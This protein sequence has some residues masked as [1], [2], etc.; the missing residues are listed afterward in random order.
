MFP[1]QQSSRRTCPPHEVTLLPFWFPESP[2]QYF[3][4]GQSATVSQWGLSSVATHVPVVGS[5]LHRT[6][7]PAGGHAGLFGTGTQGFAQ[8]P[9]PRHCPPIG[10]QSVP[11]FVPP[12]HVR[13]QKLSA[14]AAHC[15]PVRVHRDGQK[16]PASFPPSQNDLRPTCWTQLA[17]GAPPLQSAFVSQPRPAFGPSMHRFMKQLLPGQSESAV[18]AMPALAPPMHILDGHPSFAGCEKVP[19]LPSSQGVPFGDLTGVMHSPPITHSL[20][21]HGSDV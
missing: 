12:T 19:S 2:M 9:P 3:V 21:L 13:R 17:F 15:P 11:G 20:R 18:Q 14:K 10:E 8:T 16:W 5:A 4:V 7:L 1:V 6:H